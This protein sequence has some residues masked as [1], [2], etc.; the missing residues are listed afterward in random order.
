MPALPEPH[1]TTAREGAPVERVSPNAL[2]LRLLTGRESLSA[3]QAQRLLATLR[4][5]A[6]NEAADALLKVDPVDW[7]LAGQHAGNDAANL[8]RRLAAAPTTTTEATDA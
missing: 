6:I 5:A 2:A 1:T 4:T 7:A 3:D 8:L